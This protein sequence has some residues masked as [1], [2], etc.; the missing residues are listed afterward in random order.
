MFF[1]LK[2]NI[3]LFVLHD[4]LKQFSVKL[5]LRDKKIPKEIE[6]KSENYHKDINN[7]LKYLNERV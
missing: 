5:N 6:N 7:K 2:K 4:I 1:I 3:Y